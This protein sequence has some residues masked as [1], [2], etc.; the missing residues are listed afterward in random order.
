MNVEPDQKVEPAPS[1]KGL[2]E[3]FTYPLMSAIVDR[4]TRRVARGTSILSG[5]ISHTSTNKPDPL[6]PLEEAVLIVSTGLTGST[7]MHDVP[8]KNKDGEDHFAAPLINVLSRGASSIDNSHAV[9]FFM[10]NDEGTWLIK[11]QRNREALAALAK[12]PPRWENW[13]EADWLTAA[14][15][16]KHRLYKE[17]LDFP[18]RWPYYFIW[19]R[20]LS[21]RPGTTILLPIVDLTRQVINVVISL[22]SEEDGERPLFVDDRSRFRPRS[23][24]DWVALLGSRIGIVPEIPYQIIGGAKRGRDKWL[25]SDYPVPIGHYSTFRTEYETFLLLQNLM[26]VS[27]GMGLGAW[28]HAAVDAPYIFERDPAKGKFGIEFRMQK[29][30]KRRHWPPLPAPLD[31]PIGIDG[32]LESLSPPYVESMD[33]AVDRVIEEKYGPEG[34]YGDRDIFNRAYSKDEYGDAFLKMASRRPTAKVVEYTKEICNYMYDT[35]GRFPAHA[36]AFHVPGVWLQFSHLELEF[37]EKYFDP[38]LYR[39]QAA[40]HQMWGGH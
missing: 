17:R 5:P 11:Q 7:T 13:T 23:L 8:A 35:Y 10:I 31:N 30:K 3:L 38:S 24:L 21:N 15:S 34:T 19:N 22:L 2:H 14:S 12:L 9:S 18:R 25:N 32:V 33:A 4:R 27:Q 40:H 29:P 20:Q 36:N 1:H 28:L 6:S 26:L 37:Y 39:R 16:M